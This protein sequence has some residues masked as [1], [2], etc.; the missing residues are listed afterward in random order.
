MPKTNFHKIRGNLVEKIFWGRIPVEFATSYFFFVK[1]SPYQ[2]MLHQLKY[3]GRSDIGFFLGHRF[4]NE[5]KT[6]PEFCSFDEIIPVPLHPDKLKARGYNQ[7]EMIANGLSK[8]L[9]IPVDTK[10]L[11]RITYT[12]T[13]TKKSRIERWENTMDVFEAD[14]T[15]NL[16]GKHVLLV[17]DVLTTGATIEGCATELLKKNPSIKLSVVTLAFAHN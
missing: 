9:G 3:K 7:S 5:L 11:K 16:N 10:S 2:N 12:E 6:Q 15:T 14:E 8:S 17:D 4:G 1:Q 13:Q